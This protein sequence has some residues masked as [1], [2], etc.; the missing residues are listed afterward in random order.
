M[1]APSV[2]QLP[3]CYHWQVPALQP[4]PPPRAGSGPHSWSA[5]GAPSDP[6]LLGHCRQEVCGPAARAPPPAAGSGPHSRGALWAPFDPWL[7]GRCHRQ[8][9]ALQPCT[10]PSWLWPPLLGCSRGAVSLCRPAP[11]ALSLAGAWPCSPAPPP[12]LAPAPTPRELSGHRL[13]PGSWGAVVG[14]C[15]PCSPSAPLPPRA[16]SRPPLLGCS[17]DTI[18]LCLLAP[19]ALDPGSSQCHPHGHQGGGLGEPL[20]A[21]LP[22][23]VTAK[24]RDHTGQGFLI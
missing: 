2:P 1:G 15:V 6:R 14:R 23:W 24:P 5:L 11:G 13:T 19:R 18:G 7:L 10:P 4:C 20:S 21:P 8:V 22:H 17:R 3:G 9:R 12:E 16:G